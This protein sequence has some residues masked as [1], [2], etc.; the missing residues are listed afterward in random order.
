VEH[1]AVEPTC[2]L[3]AL[4]DLTK[5]DGYARGNVYQGFADLNDIRDTILKLEP[6]SLRES[7]LPQAYCVLLEKA[8]MLR[9]FMGTNDGRVPGL[10]PEDEGK[11]PSD[12]YLEFM[13][14]PP[15]VRQMLR[16]RGFDVDEV[17]L[18]GGLA[19]CY[20]LEGK[21]KL[22][23]E[24]YRKV[25]EHPDNTAP[26]SLLRRLAAR[27]LYPEGG[28]KYV[29][30]LEQA[31]RELAPDEQSRDLS[32][33][34]TMQ[35]HLIG[36]HQRFIERARPLLESDDP[37]D[38]E[39][40]EQSNRRMSLLSALGRSYAQPSVGDL[41]RAIE[42][43]EQLLAEY[44]DRCQRNIV[45][46]E[47]ADW[48]ARRKPPDYERAL[49]YCELLLSEFPEEVNAPTVARKAAWL[50]ERLDA[51]AAPRRRGSNHESHGEQIGP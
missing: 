14:L 34:I 38:R 11:L 43:Y 37:A 21:G 23:A 22:A 26:P 47:L 20:A 30:L 7:W 18:L 29:E 3:M 50:R 41:E 31:E 6:Q 5:I 8:L 27:A 28:L 24:Y 19:D 1:P 13:N 15:E 42:C 45:Y 12:Y 2:K 49:Y 48:Y 44:P 32:Y 35:Y 4:L 51:Q 17:E 36:Q 46:L 33:D 25:E 10:P 9:A 39:F 40:L 16:A